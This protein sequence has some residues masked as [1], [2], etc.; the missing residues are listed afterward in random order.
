MLAERQH[1]VVAH[2]QLLALGLGRQAIQRRVDAGRLHPLRLGVYAVG[3]RLLTREGRWLAAVLASG[4]DAVLSHHSAAALWGIRTTSRTVVDVTIP[5]KSRSWE[6]IRRHRKSLPPDEVTVEDGIPV[7]SVPRTILDLAATEPADVVKALI[8]EAEFRRHYDRLSLPHLLGRYRGS[9][10]SRRVR[11]AL[12]AIEE[13]PPGRTVS[14]L[15][16]KFVP[17]LDCHRL[18][19]PRLNDWILLGS[20]RFQVDCHWPDARQIV[21]LDSWEG[22]GTRSAFRSDRARDRALVVAG[23]HVT[24]LTYAQLEE[25]P[26]QIAAD[27]RALLQAAGPAQPQRSS[28]GVPSAEGSA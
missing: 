3:H 4:S 8:K 16:D 25:E 14:P 27:L 2:R 23:Y 10:G 22:H 17:F 1:G 15:E 21:E 26:E 5:R 9:R 13:G 28:P 18:P 11:E 19:H 20:K 12:A 7:T 6:G 24:R